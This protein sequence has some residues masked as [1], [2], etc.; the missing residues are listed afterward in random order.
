M[1]RFDVRDK[2][3]RDT[4]SECGDSAVEFGGSAGLRVRWDSAD[5]HELRD[6]A[7]GRT[8]EGL[9]STSTRKQAHETAH[10]SANKSPSQQPDSE[11]GALVA[12]ATRLRYRGP[13]W[14][15]QAKP[16]AARNNK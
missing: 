1:F 3:R 6:R 14:Q 9:E 12:A 4:A 16:S 10:N 7:S 15:G 8:P 5:S 13:G 2:S 11:Y